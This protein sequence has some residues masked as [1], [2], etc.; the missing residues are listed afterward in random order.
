MSSPRWCRLLY[1]G[2]LGEETLC[3]SCSKDGVLVAG[4]AGKN[5]YLKISLI[6]GNQ[7]VGYCR[8]SSAA[9]QWCTDIVKIYEKGANQ[10]SS[11]HHVVG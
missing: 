2:P 8:G 9:N 6:Y 3:Q 4:N 7:W 11:A 10:P 1:C 5:D